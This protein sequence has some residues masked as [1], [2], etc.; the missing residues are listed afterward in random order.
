[1][2]VPTIPASSTKT[3]YVYYGNPNATSA[4][5]GDATFDFFDDFEGTSLDTSK[6]VA[7]ANSYSVS[8]SVLRVNIG[9]I[10][11]TSAFSFN[12]Q[13]GYMA[14]TKVI[15]YGLAAN[16]GG[17]L[18]E[19]ASSSYTASG[20]ANASATILYMRGVGSATVRYWIGDGSSA[21]Y[22]VAN[23]LST[24][25]ISSDNTWYITGISVRGGEVKL[26]RDGTAIVT[27][28]G[29]TWY[30]N[31]KY[32]KLGSFH[33]GA[34]YDIQDTGYDWIRVRKY[35]SPEPTTSVGAEETTIEDN[36]DLVF[37][38]QNPPSSFT[39]GIY[40]LNFQA[41]VCY[42]D[43]WCGTCNSV[44][45]RDSTA[46]SA[47]S[48]AGF[49]NCGGN[50]PNQPNT[51]FSQCQDTSENTAGSLDEQIRRI[52]IKSLAPSG[53]FEGGELVEASL[54]LAC[55]S[56]D[57]IVIAY[58]SGVTY[59]P[60]QLANWRYL[61]TISCPY[62]APV[63]YWYNLHYTLRLDN[64]EGWHAVRAV[65]GRCPGCATQTGI[66]PS[67]T[68]RDADDFVFYVKSK[69]PSSLP[70]CAT[71][72][73]TTA[74]GDA[75][76]NAPKCPAGASAC[77]TCDLVK[78]RDSISGTAEPNQPNTLSTAPACSDDGPTSAQYLQT[79]S[80]ER[81]EIKDLSG[82][83][84]FQPGQP[85]EVSVLV[86]CDPVYP[87]YLTD[88]LVLLYSSNADSPT[89]T[90]VLTATCTSAGY[91]LFRTKIT[92]ANVAGKHVVRAIFKQGAISSTD[93][94][95][96]GAV[97]D[98]GDTDDLVFEV[99]VVQAPPNFKLEG[100]APDSITLNW[101]D[102][103][104]ETRYEI[105]WTDTYTPDYSKWQVISDN[106]SANTTWYLDSGL[107]GGEE[108]C[109]A[110]RACNGSVCSDFVW[111][112]TMVPTE[113]AR[114]AVFDPVWRVSRCEGEINRCSTCN[115]VLSRDSLARR[116]EINTP[117]AW[118][119][120]S[121]TDGG[122]GDYY[123]SRSV[124]R[125]VLS[126]G[127]SAFSTGNEI[128]VSVRV[129]CSSN[130]DY[131]HLYVSAGTS[132][133]SWSFIGS[134]ACSGSN[135]VEDKT[136]TFTPSVVGWYVIRAVV[137]GSGASTC[138]GG[139]YD[140]V[141][142]VAV[143]VGEGIRPPYNLSVTAYSTE[144]ITQYV[145]SFIDDSGNEDGFA[146]ERTS[147]G[148]SW[149]RYEWWSDPSTKSGT[150]S[151]R[152]EFSLQ[153]ETRW[154]FRVASFKQVGPLLVLSQWADNA[155]RCVVGVKAPS[156]LYV[157]SMPAL[158]TLRFF[159]QDNSSYELGQNLE[160]RLQS[161]STYTR[162]LLSAN[163]EY[164]EKQ[165]PSENVYCM[166]VTNWW[167]GSGTG[168]ELGSYSQGYSGEICKLAMGVP[169]PLN[170]FVESGVVKLTWQDNATS[171][172]GYSVE[173][174]SGSGWSVL[175]TKSPDTVTHAYT[176][177][178]GSY[179]YRVR[180][181]KGTNYS[182]YT[183]VVCA[184]FGRSACYGLLNINVGIGNPIN[185]APLADGDTI[186]LSFANR[187]SG[188]WKSGSTKWGV[189]LPTT[190]SSN[191]CSLS[192][193]RIFVGLADGSAYIISKANGATLKIKSLGIGTGSIEGC[194]VSS[195][196]EIFVAT[197]G[198]SVYK[199]DPALNILASR[200]AGS[201][202]PV[203]APAIDEVRGLVY[204]PRQD[205][206][207][208]VYDMNL[209]SVGI[210]SV[211]LGAGVSVRSGV[212]I[213]PKGE[214]YVGGTDG[215]LYMVTRVGG[216]FYV[217]SANVGGSIVVSP[218][219]Y[220]WG[221][222]V[223]V[224]VGSDTGV[225]KAFR[226][227]NNMN[228]VEIWSQTLA[229]GIRGSP[230][231]VGDVVYLGVGGN[232]E[233]RKITD[234]SSV[235][236]YSLSGGT[237]GSPLEVGGGDVVIGDS[238]G[239]LHIIAGGGEANGGG[240]WV[241][242][243]MRGKRAVG[244][245]YTT[246][247]ALAYEEARYCPYSSAPGNILFSVISAE[248]RSDY[249]G[250][251]IFAV[252]NRGTATKAYLISASGPTAGQI[253]W[254]YNVGQAVWSVPAV[255][256]I[257]GNSQP[258][259]VIG[260]DDGRVMV[261]R[262]DGSKIEISLCGKVRAVTLADVDENG[263]YEII[264]VAKVCNRVYVLDWDSSSSSLQVL[265][266]FDLASGS[267]NNSYAVWFGGKIYV[268]GLD[269]NLY[270][271]DY[272]TDITST[273]SIGVPDGLDTPAIG[274]VDGD[275]AE[276][277]V[278]GGR[279]GKVYIRSVGTGNHE[280]SVDLS[281]YVGSMTCFRVSLGDANS[282]DINEI[283][284]VATD[285][286]SNAGVS[287]LISIEWNGASSS[288]QVK[289]VRGPFGGVNVSHAVVADFDLD[290]VG[291][292]AIITHDGTLYVYRYDG[293]LSF[294]GR[295]YFSGAGAR[296]G[297]SVIDVDGDG[298]QNLVFGDRAGCVH[299]FEFGQ[300]TASGTIWWGYNRQNPQQNGLR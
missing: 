201:P 191:I 195:K 200:S 51:L 189:S 58:A 127:A 111:D 183:E 68:Y 290:R 122:G 93:T 187:V 269:G 94:C 107:T 102:V 196:G 113:S 279:D 131:V 118:Y 207:I 282:D 174:S 125:I 258:E 70:V 129:F 16:F 139:L 261:F 52:N 219:V 77:S 276:E 159:W 25:W 69:A 24:G 86:Y 72:D 172:T 14:E 234:G 148:V 144:T 199:L 97:L 74:D 211:N 119:S 161:S 223:T 293:G 84:A 242:Y 135:Q 157:E 6:W 286:I 300:G 229:G 241:S 50:E 71:Y 32:V 121:C 292:I 78:S 283:Y 11:R 235:C 248:I 176:P 108:R 193:D 22:N 87:N 168:S 101:S 136:F 192:Q 150:G 55:R 167:V 230:V 47:E 140:E 252:N 117:N 240:W 4:S 251:E 291:E 38:V 186:Y 227:D 73:N 96:G 64:V 141:D 90:R 179:C 29:I 295:Y 41:P 216:S 244:S 89:F 247:R 5:N 273:V 95:A 270:I 288:Y 163:S 250:M 109:Y 237:S 158:R 217:K 155:T 162:D 249:A 21:S 106:Y 253:I 143:R 194:A 10:E 30:K 152:I 281:S 60:T 114:C 165:F 208:L 287:Y 177:A 259:I 185:E 173:V 42:G 67:M 272:G 46:D 256:D 28:T 212:A 37:T 112:C 151:R 238:A 149:T 156:N 115:L 99:G 19:V 35:T 134:Q 236:S 36:D 34:A 267:D 182:D 209:D 180:G 79:E 76:Y 137:T 82:S 98:D 138:P 264:A 277:V 274:N 48:P 215:Y 294:V 226:L 254:W 1:V 205:G 18:P 225:L 260:V 44:P 13:D 20:N 222:E 85:V 9:G 27:V 228:L 204:V 263:D 184:S 275:G 104:G 120:S 203:T 197:S 62:A 83:G 154:C 92:L 296:G 61:T 63:T 181:V 284:V 110:I 171:E 298:R 190:I 221:A 2:R 126:T 153:A 170:V 100:I 147:D 123:S 198:G 164:Y 233:G 218:V 49:Y 59:S 3:I 45:C 257:D 103:A 246:N 133:I 56:D 285:C 8:N 271:F 289:W 169:S 57:Q 262:S 146:I 231:I 255:G 54:L 17:V 268:T 75:A 178:N 128:S 39:C 80:I 232:I 43:G 33:R 145:V 224:V 53:K 220:Q 88:Y 23:N 116:Q 142:D 175:A 31:L 105:R 206:T 202:V 66:C 214:I 15:H 188:I 245:L 297:I 130:A 239:M 40:D 213:G 243:Q 166:R 299:V 124:E 65:L 26:W 160:W 7:Y 265:R 280:D 278:F 12:I 132:P 91:N 210:G 81:I 266:R